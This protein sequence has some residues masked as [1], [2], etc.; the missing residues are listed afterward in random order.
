MIII[1]KGLPYDDSTRPAATARNSPGVVTAGLSPPFPATPIFVPG[2]PP[3]DPTKPAWVNL[4][5]GM[6]VTYPVLAPPVQYWFLYRI[7]GNNVPFPDYNTTIYKEVYRGLIQL[8]W[9]N[10]L[11]VPWNNNTPLTLMGV[12]CSQYTDLT[13][14]VTNT[15]SAELNETFTPSVSDRTPANI[16]G[17]TYAASLTW[18]A[19]QTMYPPLGPTLGGG[20]GSQGG[21]GGQGNP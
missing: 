14:T 15:F 10:R 8:P 3:V 16:A 17:N 13:L 1:Y 9:N 21:H 5:L 6:V 20:L 2:G 4:L 18:P 12:I 7:W 11:T 19:Q